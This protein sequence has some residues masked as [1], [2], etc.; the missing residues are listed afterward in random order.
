MLPDLLKYRLLPSLRRLRNNHSE[1]AKVSYS[2]CGEDLI[3]QLL[4]KVLGIDTVS[5]LDVGAHH[6]T[7]LSNTYLFYK[8]GGRGV[9]VEP[10]PSLFEEFGKKRPHDVHLNC[11]VGTFAGQ[12]DFFVMSTSTLNTF[13]KEEVERYLSYGKQRIMKTIKIELRLINDILEKHFEKC[14][15]LVS[16]D[17]EGMDY[18]ILD[19]FNFGKYRPDVFCLETLSYNEDKSER[20]LTEI[21][22]IM[23]KNGYLTYA[24]TYINTIFVDKSAWDNRP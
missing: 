5:Y 7:Y 24:D 16:L 18:E 15:N 23:H 22:D 19:C 12:V 14:P 17:V 9:C 20:K 2:Q 6:P 13:S 3:M 11:G 8:S 21:I 10:D 4:F 1:N